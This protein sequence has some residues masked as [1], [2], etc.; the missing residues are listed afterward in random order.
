MRFEGKEIY[1]GSLD[2]QYSPAIGQSLIAGYAALSDEAK[3]KILP[4]KLREQLAKE[5]RLPERK[6]GDEKGKKDDLD[7]TTSVRA[8]VAGLDTLYNNGL[9]DNAKGKEVE[10]KKAEM[11]LIIWYLLEN[12]GE[13]EPM[14]ILLF[15]LAKM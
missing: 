7:G 9:I 15:L 3:E 14:K 8:M 6:E 2:G 11:F 10:N 1:R 13:L 4:K 12:C 5:F